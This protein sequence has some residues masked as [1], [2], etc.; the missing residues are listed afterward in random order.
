MQ[1]Q[2]FWIIDRMP[3]S[4]R[5]NL[6]HTFE[7]QRQLVN[8]T[9]VPA[10]MQALDIEMFPVSENIVYDMLHIRHKNQRE[11]HLKKQQSASIQIQQAKR[12]HLN[13][14]RADVS[15]PFL[16]DFSFFID[17]IIFYKCRNEIIEQM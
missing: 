8:N 2:V 6:N 7:S 12:K 13:S 10:V 4:S 16:F 5:L 15:K 11:E 1:R 3:T 9:I 14:R 17:P